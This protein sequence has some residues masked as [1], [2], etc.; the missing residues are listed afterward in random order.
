MIDHHTQALKKDPNNANHYLHRGDA[1]KQL[2]EWDNAIADF[3]QAINIERNN[4]NFYMS[5]GLAYQAKGKLNEAIADFDMAFQL[6]PT[7]EAISACRKNLGKIADYVKSLSQ[8]DNEQDRIETAK[9]EQY[10]LTSTA[11]NALLKRAGKLNELMR[12]HS[13]TFDEAEHYLAMGASS[14]LLQRNLPVGD[15]ELP[16]E[17]YM[18]ITG[19]VITN[20][21]QKEMENLLN[22]LNDRIF[23]GAKST[24]KTNFRQGLFSSREEYKQRQQQITENHECRKIIY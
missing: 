21:S 17:L 14:W 2:G 4:A 7:D 6:K 24:A 19:F 11:F 5:R 3:T 8:I 13:L 20:F 9:Q 18:V 23:A 12:K 10:G 15:K 16:F 1:Y 22:A